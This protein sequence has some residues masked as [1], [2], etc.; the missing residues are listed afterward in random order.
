MAKT[1]IS[2]KDDIKGVQKAAKIPIHQCKKQN[3][4]I[5]FFLKSRFILYK[6]VHL[7][8]HYFKKQHKRA[9]PSLPN[10]KLSR[11]RVVLFKNRPCISRASHRTPVTLFRLSDDNIDSV[12]VRAPRNS[13]T[14]PSCDFPLPVRHSSSS[15]MF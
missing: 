6:D 9:G 10:S 15:L 3:K 7:K 5:S 1:R 14:R 13:N 12:H 8:N 11:R 4:L 2:R